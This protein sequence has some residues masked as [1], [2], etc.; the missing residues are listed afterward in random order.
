VGGLA[1]V[2]AVGSGDSLFDMPRIAFLVWLPIA[3]ALL[4]RPAATSRP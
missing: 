4:L 1:G 2:L 3:T